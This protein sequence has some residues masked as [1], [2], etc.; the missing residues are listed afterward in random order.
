MLLYR[1]DRDR[2]R[3]MK[4]KECSK[5]VRQAVFI[6]D[7]NNYGDLYQIDWD[8]KKRSQHEAQIIINLSL[9]ERF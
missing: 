1:R 5:Q 3:A 8:K 2:V 6:L 4:N 7:R 9:V